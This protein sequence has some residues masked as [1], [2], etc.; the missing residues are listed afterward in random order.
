MA[1]LEDLVQLHFQQESE[2]DVEAVLAGMTE[3]CYYL[4]VPLGLYVEGKAEVRKLHSEL[5]V[6]YPDLEIEIINIFAGDNF[7]CAETI[8]RGTNLGP[9]QGREPTR[10]RRENRGCSVF[11]F[12]GDL[13]VGERLYY[14]LRQ[15]Y[16]QL[17]LSLD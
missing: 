1:T 11:E 17:G 3:D 10:K 15:V 7:A 4:H 13:I 16:R 6:A 8:T 5:H 2:H 9:Y 14:D 12:R